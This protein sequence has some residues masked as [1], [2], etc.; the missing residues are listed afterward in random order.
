MSADRAAMYRAFDEESV[1]SILSNLAEIDSEESRRT[2]SLLDEVCPISVILSNEIFNAGAGLTLAECLKNEFR[3]GRVQFRDYNFIEGVTALLLDKGR[4][5]IWKPAVLSD[6]IKD[7]WLDSIEEHVRRCR[8][9]C[10]QQDGFIH[11]GAP[12]TSD[13]VMIDWAQIK[14][15]PTVIEHF[16]PAEYR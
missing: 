9:P 7:G 12:P 5:P 11:D 4:K 14:R 10:P 6:V 2:I 8:L 1:D 16:F 15:D 3:M 13:A